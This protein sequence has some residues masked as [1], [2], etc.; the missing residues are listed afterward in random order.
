MPSQPS[1]D[2]QA[3][4]PSLGIRPLWL[5]ST[6]TFLIIA[7]LIIADAAVSLHLREAAL[8]NTE[9]NLRNISLALAEQADRAVQGVELVLAST[10]EF[11]AAREGRRRRR[12]PAQD[13]R[14]AGPR[15][16]A[17]EAGRPALH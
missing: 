16:A 14:P 6:C 17:G 12:F 5:L 8:R 3:V 7:I 2:T 13:G 1:P 9:T 15:D 4:P 10:A 11:V